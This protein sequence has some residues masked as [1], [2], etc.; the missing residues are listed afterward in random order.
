MTEPTGEQPRVWTRAEV[1]ACLCQI[2]AKSLAV[3]EADVTPSASLVRDLGAESIDFLDIGFNIQQTLGV[4]LRTAEIRSRMT[5]WASRVHP[6]LVE[7]LQQRYG[8]AVTVEELRTFEHGGLTKIVEWLQATR[9]L[10]TDPRIGAELGGALVERLVAD[11]AALGLRIPAADQ[12]DLL[13]IMQ[14]D[15]GS[16]RLLDRTQDLLTVGALVDH[17]CGALGARVRG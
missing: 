13:D 11:F 4:S 5:A 15:L 12:G 8:I 2:L 1:E 7:I 14:A 6:A 16:R 17:L 9:D 10:P 3:P